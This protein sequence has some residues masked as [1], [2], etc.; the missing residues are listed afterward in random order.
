MLIRICKTT[1]PTP[2]IL[3]VIIS[4]VIRFLAFNECEKLAD[5]N[6]MPLYD[7][8]WQFMHAGGKY[9]VLVTGFILT[10]TQAIHLNYV[11][12]KHAVLYKNSWLPALMY[13]VLSGL[14]PLFLSFHPIILV[15]TILIFALDQIFSLYKT[16]H[17]LSSIFNIGF[18]L[19]IGALIYL[20]SIVMFILF[21]AAI[22]ILRPFSWREWIVSIMGFL[23]PFFLAFLYYF[24]TNHLME[25][26]QRL[27]VTGI[28]K[29][30]DLKHIF[31]YQYS[32]SLILTGVL[33]VLSIFRLQANYYKNVT[34]SRL[35]QQLLFIMI[36]VGFISVVVS[37]DDQL[38]RFSILAIPFSVYLA[39]YFLSGKKEWINE[40]TFLVL[41]ITWMYNFFF[42]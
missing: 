31:T 21:I 40:T 5:E 10:T 26:Y 41:L 38:Y 15:N 20:P 33:F 25:F 9:V 2:V 30:P 4:V 17:S 39:Y 18:L 3:I 42:A 7:L 29:K 14:L 12:N 35:I 34:K 36:I 32:I 22:L 11:L 8:I 6:G 27:V 24:M 19:A 16:D 37:L 13:S 23:L 28:N 1:Q